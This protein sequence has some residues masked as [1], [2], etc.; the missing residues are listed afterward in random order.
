MTFAQW[1]SLAPAAAAHANRERIAAL[2]PGQARAAIAVQ[3][4]EAEMARRF[5]AAPP[6]LPLSGV[7]FYVKDLFDVA[8]E[9][10][11]AGSIFIAGQRPLPQR[12]AALVD[13]LLAAGA[14]LAGKTH[15]YE[16]AYGLTG[17]NPHYGNC[18]HPDWPDRTSGGSSSGSAALVAAGAAPLALGT[19]TGGSIRVPAAFCG[20]YGFRMTPRD[21]WIADAFPLAPG[22]DTAGW[23]TAHAADMRRVMSALLGAPGRAGTLRGLYYEPAGL[24]PAVA[25]ALRPA[26]ARWGAV[27]D[28]ATSQEL[29][30][31]FAGSAEPYAILQSGEALAVHQAWL[32]PFRASYGAE[33]W[34]RID[35]A[36]RWT[37]DQVAAAQAHQARVRSAW[38]GYFAGHDFLTLAAAPFPAPLA[39][40]LTKDHR[41]RLLALA[42]PASLGGC[43]VLTV[44][45]AL[46]SGLTAGLQI[47]VPSARSPV[48][49]W[50]LSQ[51]AP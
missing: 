26:A 22:F 24:D 29:D 21:P 41:A 23:F 7:P 9:P 48:L 44:P 47:V 5:A 34:A 3:P 8:G 16:F 18:E 25:A 36:R 14:V 28:P 50:V 35:R 15:L 19:D 27:P 46:P 11:R 37:P 4:A 38:S 51:L 20:L 2:R 13:A 17:E 31:A 45:I 42:A 1:Q 49:D 30:H 39:R 43:P 33:V 6:D 12:N 40:E 10:T 32:D